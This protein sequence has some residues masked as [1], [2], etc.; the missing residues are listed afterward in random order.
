MLVWLIFLF[1]CISGEKDQVE[2]QET[3]IYKI[4]RDCGGIPA[5]ENNG[6]RGYMLTFVIAYIRVISHFFFPY[7]IWIVANCEH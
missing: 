2:Q 4:A 6:E 1:L 3:L 5:G 7:L